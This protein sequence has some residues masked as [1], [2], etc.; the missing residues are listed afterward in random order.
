[1]ASTP[2][3]D[4]TDIILRLDALL[5]RRN[6]QQQQINDWM[7]GSATGGPKGDGYYPLTDGSGYTRMVP[8]PAKAVG[9]S[10]MR[11][12]EFFGA[13]GDGKSHP[14]K[15]SG[16][17][18]LVDLQKV[19][20]F[21]NSIMQEMDFLAWQKMVNTPGSYMCPNQADY[22]MVNSDP[23]TW[24]PL[25]WCAGIADVDGNYSHFNF[26]DLRLVTS[27][28][29]YMPEYNFPNGAGS[30][31]KNTTDYDNQPGW[32]IY[33]TFANGY[34]QG[35]DN[36]NQQ[37]MR[38]P[39]YE[40]L[41]N[42]T[43]QPGRYRAIMSGVA[44]RGMSYDYGNG[45]PPYCTMHFK[46]ITGR[47]VTVFPRIDPT[48]PTTAW[49]PFTGQFDFEVTQVSSGQIVF[50][51]G[52][53]LDVRL[54]AMDIVRFIPNSAILHHRDGPVPH[55]FLSR[56]LRRMNISGPYNVNDRK[57]ISL[58][59]WKSFASI[60]GSL[61]DW[62]LVKIE[63]WDITL[64]WQD[65]AYLLNYFMCDVG[66]A[67]SG[68]Y[69]GEGSVNAGENIK[70]M[71][72]SISGGKIAMQNPGGAEFTLDGTIIDYNEQ[73]IIRNAGLVHIMNTRH[74]QQG[75]KDPNKPIIHC[76]TG[77]VIYVNSYYLQAG[78]IG[79]APT[80]PIWV[81]TSQ[82]SVEFHSTQVYNLSSADGVGAKG[83]GR[84]QFYNFVNGGNPN[85]GPDLISK[86]D[87]M[88][89]LGG[90]GLF[91]G[92]PDKTTVLY[93]MD[94]SKIGFE[95][96][97]V[98]NDGATEIYGQWDSKF[99]TA[100]ISSDYA[101]EGTKS[102]K[103]TKRSGPN[104]NVWNQVQ[105]LVPLPS[106]GCNLLGVVYFAQPLPYTDPETRQNFPLSG[107]P[108]YMRQFYVRVIGRDVYGRPI[109]DRR[110]QF[111]GEDDLYFGIDGSVNPD[112]TPKWTRRPLNTTYGMAYPDTFA[113]DRSH[114]WA[115]HYLIAFDM[116]VM[117]AGSFYMDGMRIN[118]IG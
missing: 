47:S 37:G 105:F 26:T 35:I 112:G 30:T 50:K 8:S 18:T 80:P 13:F 23:S 34:A 11:G 66:G 31:W 63:N 15:S 95:G 94:P 48:N 20:P 28:D 17:A 19:Y 16:F 42:V 96:G 62:E 7:A 118:H 92:P 33:M 53:Y 76:T 10:A 101:Y 82:S 59:V 78:A 114:A 103:M 49:V 40:L 24:Q 64:N 93:N 91:E 32:I 98:V 69:F 81:D 83:A 115:S 72:G 9:M 44:K 51:G 41:G 71:Q 73:L 12:P 61:Q 58:C 107:P 117:P 36:H 68:C 79:G 84:V 102:L 45:N 87:N 75:P 116:Q 111:K 99:L 106:P 52:G 88:D 39:Y 5:G 25:D 22:Y 70:F 90:A 86:S 46:G 4:N 56:R 21:A 1:M 100:E 97:I 60:D 89:L 108:I 65:G 74:E 77:R 14:A 55:Y 6:V 54:Q 85:L 110:I 38:S 3:L 43:L 104:N 29:H 27:S 67:D 113:S 109:L 57:G 2:S